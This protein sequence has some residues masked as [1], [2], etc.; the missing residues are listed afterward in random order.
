MKPRLLH[1]I[2]TELNQDIKNYL[3]SL[4]AFNL[5][6]SN[7]TFYK[8]CSLQEKDGRTF[9]IE[10]TGSGKAN[11]VEIDSKKPLQIYHRVLNADH[12]N[13]TS[14]GY[15]AKSHRVRNFNMILVCFGT[16]K[17]LNNPNHDATTDFCKHIIDAIPTG[18]DQGETVIIGNENVDMLEVMN[19]EFEGATLKNFSVVNIAFTVEYT[20]IQRSD[21]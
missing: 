10:K 9:P 16:L 6:G 14:L 3:N 21:C 13:N 18:L 5:L 17:Y 2:L 11:F 4:S 12:E 7:T 1:D 20:I 8:Q 15:G 19:T